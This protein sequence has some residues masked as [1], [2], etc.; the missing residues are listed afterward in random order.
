MAC[1]MMHY[2][3]YHVECLICAWKN[4]YSLVVGFD[5]LCLFTRPVCWTYCLDHLYIPEFLSDC[6]YQLLRDHILKISHIV[7]GVISPLQCVYFWVMYFK[8]LLGGLR[9][10]IIVISSRQF[11]PFIIMKFLSL[12][13]VVLFV[14]K[15]F[16]LI[17]V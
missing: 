4:A 5:V 10:L 16:Y 8:V 6:F 14:F 17:L 1:F 9:I 12:F 7:F 2:M 11:D 15:L 3:I 13:L